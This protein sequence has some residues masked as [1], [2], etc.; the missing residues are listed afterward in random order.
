M[1]IICKEHGVFEMTP[2]N[3]LNGHGCPYCYDLHNS[4]HEQKMCDF[5]NEHNIKYI[6]QYTFK[7]L[8]NKKNMRLDFYLPEFNIAIEC[9]GQ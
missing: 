2:T 5:L 3:H 7:W 1:K 6:R 4:S 8:K 9:Q